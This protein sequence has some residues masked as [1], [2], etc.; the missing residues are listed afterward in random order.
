[1]GETVGILGQVEPGTTLTQLV[2]VGSDESVV[3]STIVCCNQTGG[4]LAI[5]VAALPVGQP[6][7]T[8]KNYLEYNTSLPA[9][10]ALPLTYGIALGPGDSLWVYAA[11]S[12]VSFTAFGSRVTL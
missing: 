7:V 1:V 12:G 3:V 9:A 4:A 5:R 2:L 6:S 8:S 10:E 11:A